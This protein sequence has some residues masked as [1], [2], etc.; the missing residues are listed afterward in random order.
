[1]RPKPILS[2]F[3]VVVLAIIIS[4]AAA[5]LDVPRLQ[6]RVNDTAG[7]LSPSTERQLDALLAAHTR[8]DLP[9]VIVS[10][11]VGMGLVPPYPMGRVYRDALGR[12]NQ[13][14]ASLADRVYFLVAG[15]PMKLKG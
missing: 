1:M 4:G 6:G 11:E 10:N 5:A 8:L 3:V 15:L 7:I 13:R 12:A 14:L 2:T 9:L